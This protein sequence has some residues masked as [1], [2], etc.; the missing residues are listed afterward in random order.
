MVRWVDTLGKDTFEVFS[1]DTSTAVGDKTV[2]TV[3]PVVGDE[4]PLF[5]VVAIVN[6]VDDN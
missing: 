2:R 3:R 6:N 4:L 5:E 1:S